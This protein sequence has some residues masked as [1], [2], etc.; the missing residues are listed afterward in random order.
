MTAQDAVSEG[1]DGA[2]YLRIDAMVW[3]RETLADGG[4]ALLDLPDRKSWRHQLFEH[5]CAYADLPVVAQLGWAMHALGEADTTV[6]LDTARALWRMGEHEFA[7]DLLRHILL[8][9]PEQPE[10][11]H[12]HQDWSQWC[13]APPLGGAMPCDEEL[14]LQPLGHHHVDDFRWQ[15]VD[16]DIAML[17][18]LPSFADT[19]QWHAWLDETW[20]GGDQALL[21]IWHRQWGFIGC[22]GLGVYEDLGFFHYWL[23][24]EFRGYGF[25]PR[26]GRVLLNFAREHWGVRACYAKVYVSNASSQRGLAKIGFDA[27]DIPLLGNE[28]MPEL[29]M[30]WPADE[31]CSAEEARRL[32]VALDIETQ[33]ALPLAHTAR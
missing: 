13:H 7:G 9:A 24:N 29:L 23:G 15:Y 5:A 17:C 22:V 3:L 10:A 21:G 20:G 16:P 19:E 8:S 31:H 12:L 26:A 28:A 14:R 27:T 25:G 6:R 4:D 32:F 1:T 2:P 11:R 18:N 33:V 30:H